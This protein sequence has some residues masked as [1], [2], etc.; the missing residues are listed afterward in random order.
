MCCGK[1]IVSVSGD[2]NA[3]YPIGS[4][5]SA[6]YT[7]KPRGASAGYAAMP[8][9]NYAPA[10]VASYAPRRFQ[11]RTDSSVLYASSPQREVSSIGYE[12]R[13]R[14]TD[15]GKTRLYRAMLDVRIE[16]ETENENRSHEWL[17][18]RVP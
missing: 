16:E 18:R 15:F 2:P 17:S 7:G 14:G 8:V 13:D 12:E 4:S 11:S 3:N 9:S 5:A 10:S 1:H 6:G